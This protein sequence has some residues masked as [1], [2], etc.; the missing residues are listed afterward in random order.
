[1]G[2]ILSDFRQAARG[3]RRAPVTTASAVLCLALGIGATAAISSAVRRALL[4][5]LPFAHPQ[6]LV[7]VSRITPETG[8][9]GNWPQSVPNYLDLARATRQL[10]GLAALTSGTALLR[11]PAG[12]EEVRKQTVTGN[13]FPLLGVQAFRGRLLRPE[14]GQLGQPPVAVLDYGFWRDRLGGDPAVVGRTLHIDGQPTTIVGITPPSFRIPTG[15]GVFRGDVWMPLRFRPEQLSQRRA[16]SLFLLGRLAPGATVRTAQVEIRT[17]F[18]NIVAEHP[19]LSGENMRVAVLQADAVRAI[20]PAL[21]LLFGAVCVVLLIAAAN[22]A[23]L[24]LA[25]GVGRRRDMAVRAALGVTRWGAMRPVLAEGLLLGGVGTAIGLALAAGGVRTI[26]ALAAARMP[27]L[28][29]FGIDARVAGFAVT[30][31]FLVALACGAVPAWR[32]A[33]VHP[34]ESLGQA[35]GGAIGRGQH[36]AL[37]GLIVAEIALSLVLLIGAGL[38]LKGFWL[39]SRSTPG[40]DASRVLTMRVTVPAAE[41][42]D[43]REVERFLEPVLMQIRSLPGIE[44]AGAI[45]LL[46]Y[47][48]WGNNANIRYE[49]RP[50]A[51]PTTYPLVEQRSVDPGF[52]QV[53]GQRLLDGRLLRVSDDDRLGAPPVVV[54]DR[55]LAV[56]DFDGASPVGKRFYLTDTSFATIVGEVRDIKNVGPFAP[57]APEMYWTYRQ[58]GLHATS[59]PIVIRVRGDDPTAVTATVRSTIQRLAPSA[60]ISS[61]RP[62]EDVISASLGRPRFYLSMLG[63]FAAVA[64]LLAVAGLYGVLSYAVAQRTHEIGIRAALGGTRGGLVRLIVFEGLRL[65]ALGIGLGAI[66]GVIL[67]RFMHSM[68]YGVSPLDSLA[69]FAAAATLALAALGGSILPARRAALL[70]PIAALRTGG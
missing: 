8:P 38:V 16:N 49:G 23:A 51:D 21:L 25:R 61:V 14:D 52:F 37:R 19:K 39:L 9:L 34:Q 10:S 24:L 27:Q 20:R 68:L 35:R 59:F 28:Q 48:D 60:A 2:S 70:D 5:P 57:P 22:V 1:M 45:D 41:F 47:Q 18:H 69:W 15:S 31:A 30:L 67:T 54:V 13:L 63:G 32:A 7:A 40:F 50:S 36:R 44:A 55:A 56:R 43:H 3:L 33:S 26:G 4:Q 62:M 65:V 58:R 11:L 64:L 29:G 46:P 66:G 53:T 12:G 17:L 6:R 42:P